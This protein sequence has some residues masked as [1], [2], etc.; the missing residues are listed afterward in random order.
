MRAAR[1]SVVDGDGKEIFNKCVKMDES[2]YAIL[3][4]LGTFFP[5]PNHCPYYVTGLQ[6]L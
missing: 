6:R 2:V 1:V 5:L 4:S 3:V